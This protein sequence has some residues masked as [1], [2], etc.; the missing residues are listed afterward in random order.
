MGV[1]HEGERAV[2]KRAGV[3]AEARSLGRG[4]SSVLPAGIGPFVEAQRMAILAAADDRGR[5]W[6]SLVMGEPGFITAPDEHNLSLAAELLAA[7][8][9]SARL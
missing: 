6:A 8:P 9:I 7:D 3:S 2:Q 1:F 4:I 5:L